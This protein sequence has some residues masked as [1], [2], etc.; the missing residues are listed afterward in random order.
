[1][2]VTYVVPTSKTPI[3]GAINCYELANGLAR[4]GHD[5]TIVHIGFVGPAE[6]PIVH[7]PNPAKRLE[8]VSWWMTFEP[9]IR[10]L[11]PDRFVSSDLPDGDVAFYVTPDPPAHA[12]L[13]L[14]MVQ[15]LGL[16]PARDEQNMMRAP[17]PKVCI[18]Q[19]LVDE[20]RR[21]GAPDDQLVY[22]PPGVHHELFRLTRPLAGRP[23][24]VAMQWNPLPRKGGMEVLAALKQVRRRIPDLSV[25]AFG[26]ASM[27]RHGTRNWVTHM[28]RPSREQLVDEVYNA[29]RIFVTAARS[30]GFGMPSVEAMAC[31][32]ALVTVDNGG[33]GD[34][35]FPG[36]TALVAQPGDVDALV[37]YIT[38]LLL[39][40]GYRHA[41]SE[42]GTQVARS[43]TWDRS[44]ALLESFLERYVAHPEKFVA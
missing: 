29:S 42:R 14:L 9:S 10:H 43:F 39:D 17:C 16:A 25:V 11:F 21:A 6:Q 5:V 28:Q 8:D 34:F 12:G 19:W 15:G 41:M 22:V 7:L 38:T 2:R 27:G 30:E 44:A 20:C 23:F 36:D 35:A 32:C 13:P 40:D 3:G 33:S 18:S 1:M 24:H 4:R 31:G 26:A 37:Q